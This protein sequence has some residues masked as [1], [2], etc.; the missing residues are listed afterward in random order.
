MSKP[1]VL[2]HANCADG[3]CSAWIARR[4]MPD[5]EFVAVNYS[6]SPP[7]VT[8]LEV[9]I[10][11]FSYKRPVML[12]MLESA[13]HTVILDHHKTAVQELEGLVHDNRL[14][15]KN[16]LIIF[17]MNKSGGRL[18]WEYFFP[19]QP[20]PWLVDYTEDRDLWLW[21]LPESKELNAALA[22]YP[23]TFEQWD[24]L[25]AKSKLGI[26]C[27]EGAAILRYQRQTVESQ[28]KNA[29]EIEMDGHRVLSLNATVLI[30]EIGEKLAQG[31]PFSAT[32]FIRGDG[33]KVWSLRSREGGIDVSEI[34]KQ[35]GGGGH[36][37]TAG[38]TE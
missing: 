29:V 6:E 1:L 11:D 23:Q 9:Y 2:F 22:S 37:A 12:E 10:L 15:A 31:R 7:D 38:F 32:Y 16:A 5:A 19:G 3:F 34:A 4:A 36:K 18:T 33:K 26:L 14:E 30:S 21:K 27:K 24:D 25:C 17:D 13:A 35:H 8:G 28:A 20:S